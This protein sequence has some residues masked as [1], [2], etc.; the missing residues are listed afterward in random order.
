MLQAHSHSDSFWLY[1]HPGICQHMVYIARGVARGEYHGAMPATAIGCHCTCHLVTV[2]Q[3]TGHF[4][5]EMHL[6][7]TCYYSLADSLDNSGQPVGAYMRVCIDKNLG[8]SA[9]LVQNPKYFVDR[10]ALLAAGV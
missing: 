1:R 8:L 6:A 3:K 4:S 7:A 10:P 2:H 9:M 5:S